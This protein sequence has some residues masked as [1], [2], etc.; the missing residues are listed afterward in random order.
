[1]HSDR[2]IAMESAP[3]SG[4]SSDTNQSPSQAGTV[5]DVLR[6]FSQFAE[7]GQR[8]LATIGA[9]S[10]IESVARGECLMT[11]GSKD[12]RVLFLVDGQLCLTS[13][14]GAKRVLDA[15]DPA[16]GFAVSY[17]SPCPCTITANSRATVLTVARS[18]L[19]SIQNEKTSESYVVED[20]GTGDELRDNLLF[21]DVY[22]ACVTETLRLPSLPD[23]AMKVRTAV[24]DECADANRV[25]RVVEADPPI[26]VKLIKAANS[27]YAGVQRPVHTTSAAIVRLGTDTTKRLVMGFALKELFVAETPVL[28]KRM[29]Q[30]WADSSQIAATCFAVAEDRGDFDPD[31]AL[32][33]G[34][35]HD[36]GVIPIVS[37]SCNYPEVAACP[38]Q[39]EQVIERMRGQIG[40]MVLRYW[41]FAENM[42]SIPVEVNE[43]FRAP[44]EPP[45]YYALVLFAKYLAAAATPARVSL[46]P[47]HSIPS[48]A[49][50]GLTD[51]ADELSQD[52]ACKARDRLLETKALLDS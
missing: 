4:Q 52:L 9:E 21:H 31:A 40:C 36:I 41:G 26:A 6:K 28:E 33:A 15:G 7:L 3:R 45:D 42:I 12:D 20:V 16:A 19:Q 38:D 34:L 22:Q 25:A 44:S 51:V 13:E 24:D 47:I 50:L 17:L 37:F 23:V 2:V 43:W 49:A 8:Q 14:D 48:F 27:A 46:P 5:A 11:R 1:M 35:L 29:Q 39:L 10:S 30:L 32:L 18:L